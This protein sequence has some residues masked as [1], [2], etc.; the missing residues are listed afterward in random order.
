MPTASPSFV[1][2]SNQSS[3]V[4]TWERLTLLEARGFI[5]YLIHL[6]EESSVERQSM[7]LPMSEDSATFTGL[8]KCTRY[9]VSMST[10]TRSSGATGPGM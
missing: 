2:T 1:V 9:E 4:V 5:E 8:E 6:Y 10:R 7:Q 3:I